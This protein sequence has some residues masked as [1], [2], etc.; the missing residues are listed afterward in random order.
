MEFLPAV[1]MPSGSVVSARSGRAGGPAVT[2]DARKRPRSDAG[3]LHG[4][5][6][7]RVCRF[8]GHG[9]DTANPCPSRHSG[10]T[11]V[12][13]DSS[14]CLPCK[15]Y[16]YATL[17]DIDKTQL[18]KDLVGSAAKREEYRVGL[19]QHAAAFDAASGRQLRP[20]DLEHVQRPS[21]LTR[22]K[23]FT[24]EG[25]RF[26]GWFWPDWVLSREKIAFDP[27][28]LQPYKGEVGLWNVLP[29]PRPGCVEV[30]ER[31][32]NRL[33]PQHAACQH[34]LRS[35]EGGYRRGGGAGCGSE[36]EGHDGSGDRRGWNRARCAA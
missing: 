12:F 23:E 17:K 35:D 34:G 15:N 20:A 24:T 8:C 7:T 10:T 25:K 14:E 29:Q 2:A 31:E 30:S 21:W 3:D 19:S 4:A 1:A 36:G 11:R 6:K 32:I 13:K 16:M 33:T 27:K 28:A 9:D 18:A 22:S 5:K 26:W